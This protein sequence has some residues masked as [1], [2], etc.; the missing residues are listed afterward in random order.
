MAP[1]LFDRADSWYRGPTSPARPGRCSTTWAACPPTS[2][3]G[4]SPPRTTTRGSRSP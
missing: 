3:S 4:R 1:S 2:R